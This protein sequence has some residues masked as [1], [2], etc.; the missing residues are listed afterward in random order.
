MHCKK[1]NPKWMKR[2]SRLIA[3]LLV[4]VMVFSH[5]RVPKALANGSDSEIVT[6]SLRGRGFM[7]AEDLGP[8]ASTP[9]VPAAIFNTYGGRLYAY[10]AAVGDVF[11]VVDVESNLRVDLEQMPGIGTAY[12]HTAAP[13]G[14]IYVAGDAGVLYMYDPATQTS[15]KIGT[16]LEGHQVWSAA[17]DEAGN[18]YFGTYKSGGAHVVKYNASTAKLEDL[19]MAD[20]SGSSDYVRSMAYKDDKL[21]LGLG[22]AAKVHVMDL[23]NQNKITDITPSDLHGRIKKDP[24]DGV[25]QYVYSMGIAGE[26]LMAHVDNGK[27]DALLFYHLDKQQWDDKVLLMDGVKDEENYDFGVWNF[28]HLPVY[29]DYAYLIHDRQL[30]QINHKTLDIVEKITKYPSGLRGGT[31][32]L[33]GGNP[34]VL[35]VSRGGEIV[36]MD[37]AAKTTT[38]GQA[39]V[40]GAPLGLHNLTAGNNGKLYMTTYPGGPKGAEYDPKTQEARMYNQGQ[41]EGIIAGEGDN[42]YF[43][44]YPGAIIQSMDTKEPGKFQTLFEMKI[45]WEQDRPYIMQYQDGLLLIGTIPDYGKTGGALAIYN[46]SDGTHKVYRNVVEKQSIVGLAMKDGIIY[47]STSQKGGLNAPSESLPTE[48]PKVFVWDVASETKTA[49]FSMDIPGLNTPMIS[50]LTFD[51][52]GNLWGAAVGILFTLDTDT[53]TVSKYKNI[54][55]EVSGRGMWR[56][57]HIKFGADG[58]LYT[59]LAGKL[60]VVDPASENWDHVTLPADGKEVDFIELAYDSQGRQNVYFLDNGAT[61][62]KVVPVIDG[63]WVQQPP[64]TVEIPTEVKN[65]G[66][67]EFQET[68]SGWSGSG[69]SLSDAQKYNGKNS[70]LVVSG[71]AISG[72]IVNLQQDKAFEASA[73]VYAV[74]GSAIVTV[75]FLDAS[76][77]LLGEQ[78]AN[79]ASTDAWEKVTV[80]GVVPGDAVKARI[81]VQSDDSAYFDAF[82]M[83]STTIVPNQ[84]LLLNGDFS[85][86]L[87]HWTKKDQVNAA[88]ADV[89]VDK[90]PGPGGEVGAGGDSAKFTDKLSTAGVFLISDRMNVTVGVPYDFKFNLFMNSGTVNGTD[91]TGQPM[92][93][94]NRCS[95][96]VRYYDQ[97]GT[98]LNSE[99]SNGKSYQTGQGAWMQLSERSTA[100]AGAVSAE[101]WIGLSPYYMADSIYFTNL[102]FKPATE[103]VA[104]PMPLSISNASLEEN[105][106]LIPGWTSWGEPW[107]TCSYQ[108]TGEQKYAGDY[109]LKIVDNSQDENIFLRSDFITLVPGAKYHEASV[110]M[111]LPDGNATLM[112]RYY[113]ADGKQLGQDQDGVN[114]IHVKTPSQDWKEVKATVTVPEGAVSAQI[115]LGMSKYFTSTGVYYD[116]V[117]L[118]GLVEKYALTVMD[119]SG[120]GEYEKGE[121]VTITAHTAPAGMKF[122]RWIILSGSGQLESATSQ[123]TTFIMGDKST[124]IKATYAVITDPV[125]PGGEGG[126]GGN[127]GGYTPSE[128][129]V[130]TDKKP[131]QPTIAST[132]LTATVNK[133]G[134]AS[135]TITEEQVKELVDK[136]IKDAKSSGKTADGMGVAFNIG[137]GANGK[138]ASLKLD[139]KALLLLESNGVV[140]FD[141]NTPLVNV[142]F[143]G[144]AIKQINGQTSGTVTIGLLPVGKLSKEAKA[145]IGKRPVYDLTVS[146]QKDG[147]TSYIKNFGKGKVTLAIAYKAA[148]KGKTGNLFGVYVDKNGKPQL[149]TKSS[150]TNGRLIFSRNTLSVY[151]VG[152]KTPAPAFTDTKNHWAKDDIDFVASRGLISGISKTTFDTKTAI[153]R[154]TFL[155]ALGKLSDAEVSTYKISSFTDVK[156]SDPAMPYIEWAVKN[157][158]VEGIGNNK[159][160]PGQQITREE[161]AVIMVSYG[162]A[163]DYKLPISIAAVTFSDSTK[164]AA[165]A[166]DA[167]KA[168]Q[169][170]GIILDKGNNI[171]DPQGSV[172]R[173]EGSVILRRFVELVIDEGTAR[174]WSQND[175]G[176]KCYF[177]S[178]GV[179]K[180]G[181]HSENGVKYYFD[182]NGVMEA[183]KWVQI[184]NKRYYFYADGK[185]AVNTTIDGYT[186]EADGSRKE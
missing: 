113:G 155:M 183:G 131:D 109:S 35:T 11:S 95:M 135:V 19:G 165:N 117:K 50:G 180:T 49:E 151:G 52:D 43:G 25:V 70:M 12:T 72:D 144:A 18:I 124:L 57:V 172:T 67:E 176:Q 45:T 23:K 80:I 15:Q 146:Y 10:A 161:M 121:A 59:D 84:E 36:Y 166:K 38:R 61:T 63:G 136:A 62:L 114:I 181:W 119:G 33:K 137:F 105:V 100:P 108:I 168:I 88:L 115:W 122:D 169:Q 29:G 162:K 164:I 123:N 6:A 3:S 96:Y 13:D 75:Q 26:T 138:G 170:A 42:I 9:N 1:T 69:V 21:Y 156:S 44:I 58:L 154:G 32:S 185:M 184:G 133:N 51:K 171:F 86:G 174:G 139:E 127:G 2:G 129:K 132:N 55:P 110:R 141:V 22:L 24:A 77:Q 48:P 98:M 39:S 79:T 71:S 81:L 82:E 107:S 116:D 93:Q 125:N 28:T 92:S 112:L 173:A 34:V 74:S 56:P 78:S 40:M 178:N 159:F 134:I 152:Y 149:L 157:K 104:V 106:S 128:P 85:N 41:A 167:V 126:T 68:I 53:N 47:G 120:S 20:P 102:S 147:K 76:G 8:M 46:P 130:P 87:N 101:V 73:Q 4:G 163:T 177:D 5:R 148:S 30:M 175:V 145:L 99:L 103:G 182:V 143:D 186:V 158:I 54:Y 37:V 17:G 160:G 91:G 65:G 64:K 142:S 140:R 97:S 14:K 94:P 118:T 83:T 7:A 60:T 153:T 179:M 150:Y 27:K 90:A 16:V 31:V 111:L 89:V 66:F